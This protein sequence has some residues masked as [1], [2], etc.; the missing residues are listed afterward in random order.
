MPRRLRPVR[1]GANTLRMRMPVRA[2]SRWLLAMLL[3]ALSPLAMAQA[4][5]AGR[6]QPAE[7]KAHAGTKTASQA[8]I[9]TVVALLPEQLV[10]ALPGSTEVAWR[11]LPQDVHGRSLGGTIW[12]DEALLPGWQLLNREDASALTPAAVPL[13]TSGLA[14]DKLDVDARASPHDEADA[15]AR[16]RRASPAVR[17]LIHELA[18][19]YDRSR[20]GGVSRDPRFLDLAGWPRKPWAWGERGDR[21]GMSDRSPDGYEL[22]KPSEYFAVNLE[23]YLLDPSYA[24]RRPGMARYLA[25]RVGAA[26]MASKA[27]APDQV[28]AVPASEQGGSEWLSVDPTRVYAVDY[29]LAEG[30][31]QAMSRWGH[32]ML[33]L[34][35]CAPGRAP[36]PDCRLDLAHHRVLS[37]RAF[38]GDVQIS[39]WRGLTGSYPSRLF[40][41]PLDQVIEE[42]TR[43]ELRGLQ[44]IPLD[45][46]RQEI[47]E[48]VERAAQLHWSYDGRY[49]FISNNCAVETW[50]LLQD[51]VPRLSALPLRGITPNGLASRLDKAGVADASVLSDRARASREGY[52]FEPLSARFD[53]LFAA[54]KSSLALPQKNALAWLDASPQERAPWLEQGD[55]RTS[56]ALLVL[57]EAA[58]RRQ[59]LRVRDVLKRRMLGESD[60][61]TLQARGEVQQWLRDAE[62]LSRPA[63]LS[64][65]GYGLPQ[66]DE[67]AQLQRRLGELGVRQQQGDRAM[68][69]LARALLPADEL[70]R[71]LAV[72]ANVAVIGARVRRLAGDS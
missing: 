71:L 14:T 10:S 58:L 59:E 5:Q 42:Y 24:C 32:S 48:L 70:Q 11:S 7:G 27:C 28:F 67:R 30:N 18:H 21:N 45:L 62:F 25:E 16:L 35:I 55:L 2:C 57:E 44:S 1:G 20:A 53:T 47:G 8:L 65:V 29:L 68:R 15:A 19:R 63:S 49:Y 64:S 43:T 33:R 13:T 54:A 4:A 36:G 40:V 26:P 51:S 69:A 72:E 66:A 37:F 41:L 9:D 6:L 23:W 31:E 39:S 12:I 22:S 34:V 56:A 52:Y 61:Q 46:S 38:V 60:A 3:L 17:A 50:R